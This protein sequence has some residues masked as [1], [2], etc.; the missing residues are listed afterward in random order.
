MQGLPLP[1][2]ALRRRVQRGKHVRL[3]V[4]EGVLDQMS[5]MR[6]EVRRRVRPTPKGA[7]ARGAV[8]GDECPRLLQGEN[9]GSL[10]AHILYVPVQ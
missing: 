10:V 7:G 6:S 2:G 1:Q 8:R 3:A 5:R 4:R 9:S